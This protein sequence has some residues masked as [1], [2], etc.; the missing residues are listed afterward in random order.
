M[1]RWMAASLLMSFPVLHAVAQ[2]SPEARAR[3]QAS[4]RGETDQV[5]RRLEVMS[6]IL[7]YYKLG[8]SED[9]GLMKDAAGALSKL[10]STEMQAVL[11]HLEKAAKES[12]RS[13]EQTDQAYS[14]HLDVVRKLREISLRYEAIRSLEMAADRLEKSA[15]EQGRI[16]SSIAGEAARAEAMGDL[17]RAVE[18]LGRALRFAGVGGA[19]EADMVARRGRVAASARADHVARAVLVGAEERAAPLHALGDP[20]FERVEARIGAA[21]VASEA[22][23]HP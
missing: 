14:R 8:A 6:G 17:P 20:R 3:A 16:Q 11:D 12:A 23:S 22:V 1:R 18:A 19:A 5:T 15:R 7:R 10:S 13:A 2:D 9:H 21:G 4:V